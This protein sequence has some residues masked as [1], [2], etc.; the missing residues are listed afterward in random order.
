MSN[1]VSTQKENIFLKTSLYTLVEAF[2][3][4]GEVPVHAIQ[5]AVARKAEITPLLLELLTDIATYHDTLD[6]EDRHDYIVAMFVLAQF[7]ETRA[8][9]IILKMA[10]GSEK[11]VDELF[12]VFLM[13]SLA[14][15][16]VSTYD[17]NLAALTTRIEDPSCFAWVRSALLESL[18][19]LWATGTITREWL[20]TYV[21]GLFDSPLMN[22]K[23]F[24]TQL[25]VE[26]CKL[27][28]KGLFEKI[29]KA[30]AR[31]LID[32][33]YMSKQEVL[34]IRN[35]PEEE[36][37]AQFIYDTGAHHMP[38]QSALEEIVQIYDAF[39]LA[40]AETEADD[41]NDDEEDTCDDATCM[42]S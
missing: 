1:V 28:N 39:E 31:K 34:T 32:E 26:A 2:N 42:H 9:P 10:S 18:I 5:A 27:Y 36:L 15:F 16:I 35:T 17:G 41:M 13:T 6:L 37:L 20:V 14:K 21:S 11:A 22:D 24:A 38:V 25:T 4:T 29:D 30:Y 40:E 33:E 7:R 3:Q 8:F 23:I 19:G 12:G